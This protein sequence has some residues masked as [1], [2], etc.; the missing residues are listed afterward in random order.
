MNLRENGERTNLDA[1]EWNLDT[2]NVDLPQMILRDHQKGDSRVQL[3]P[4]KLKAQLP[5]N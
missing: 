4:E 5:L 1:T 2:Y 3:H